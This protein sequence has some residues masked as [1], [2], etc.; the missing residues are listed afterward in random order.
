MAGPLSVRVVHP[1][2]MRHEPKLFVL[3]EP[4]HGLDVEATHLFYGL[5]GHSNNT[6]IFGKRD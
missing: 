4:T 2:A 1:N 6:R 3:D 5:V